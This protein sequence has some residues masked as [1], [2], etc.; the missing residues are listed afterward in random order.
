MSRDLVLISTHDLKLAGSLR[1]AFQEIGYATDLVTPD[2]ELTRDDA[3]LLVLTGGFEEGDSSLA[4]Q[5]RERL[6]IPVFA[7]AGRAKLPPAIRPGFEEVFSSDTAPED[8]ALVGRTIIERARL[9]RITGIVGRTEAMR[10]VLERVVQIAPVLSTVLITGESGTGK[11]LVARGVH[12]LSPR[13]NKPF[14]AVNVAA[15]SETLLESELFGH[16]KG[17]FTGAIDARRGLFE[18]AHG[19]TIFLDE[20]GEMPLATQTKLLRVL[21]QREFYRVGG[22]KPVKVDVRVIAAT[23]QD[24]G[25]LVAIGEFRRDLYYRL[26]ILSIH[27]PPLRERRED[28]P[29]LVEEFVRE[30]SQRHGR[31]FAGISPEAMAVLREYAWPGNVRELRNL[32]E[33]MVVLSPG[34]VIRPED[35]PEEVR[36]GRAG[37]VLPVAIPRAKSADGSSDLRPELEFIFRTLVNLRVDV[38]E[39]R[40]E[41]EAYRQQTHIHGIPVHT[42][43]PG[44][45]FAATDRPPAAPAA[46]VAADPEGAVPAGP[47]VGTSEEAGDADPGKRAEVGPA[48]VDVEFTS[49]EER[50]GAEGDGV[51]V[52]QPGMTM[53]EMERRAI[54]A[55]LETV[56][57]NRRKAAELLGIGERTLYR[58]ISKYGMDA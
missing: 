6:R 26:N 57:G 44:E 15:L 54:A 11:E 38:E 9:Q 50:A 22:E 49:L 4:R 43:L 29:L 25:Q 13:K 8:I 55:A 34:R 18:L 45:A 36:G 27:L 42:A 24:L 31:S 35:I 14:I 17:A 52:F 1:E 20:I 23:N 12:M 41:F 48:A 7:V 21:E 53:E 30:A 3:V 56:G 5:A 19:G 16:E 2:E 37:T 32:V 10:E 47:A 58:K 40:R 39:L 51:I 46:A 33:S 28:I